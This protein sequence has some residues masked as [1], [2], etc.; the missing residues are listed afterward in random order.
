MYLNVLNKINVFDNYILHAIRKYLK[1]K[2]LDRLMPIVTLMGNAGIIW[3]I[4]AIILILDKPYKAIGGIVLLTL[5]VSTVIG[6]GIVKHIVRR[7]RPCN[8]KNN[9]DLLISR[10]ISY[11]FPSGHTNSSFAVAW[12]LSMYFSQYKII[13][14]TMALLIS[15]SR[16]YLYV[17]YPTDVIGGVIIGILCSKLVFIILNEVYIQNIL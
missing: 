14:I 9:T 6:E 10:P 11:S 16:L 15:L 13:F 5:I 4:V 7:V 2:Y 1:N 17:H 3:I 8:D 12:V